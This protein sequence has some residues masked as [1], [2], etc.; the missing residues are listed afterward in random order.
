M[1]QELVHLEGVESCGSM[2]GR[3]VDENR[4][5]GTQA[6]GSQ[7][8]S[9]IARMTQ[10]Q[11][12]LLNIYIKQFYNERTMQWVASDERTEDEL[13]LDMANSLS[14]I[15]RNS[16]KSFSVDDWKKVSHSYDEVLVDDCKSNT[17]EYLPSTPPTC[18]L[19]PES[20]EHG[21]DENK[22][23]MRQ[24]SSMSKSEMYPSSKELHTQIQIERDE[25][26]LE[27]KKVHE[28]QR[29]FIEVQTV[30]VKLLD[31]LLHHQRSQKPGMKV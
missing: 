11:T 10:Q 6:N 12:D 17:Q 4:R 29:K 23:T 19:K 3:G 31:S 30:K 9:P 8:T 25:V 24:C 15:G 7:R 22:I 20:E 27:I 18:G 1:H 14:S 2:Q 13:W 26:L 5:I 16:R 21:C 28:S